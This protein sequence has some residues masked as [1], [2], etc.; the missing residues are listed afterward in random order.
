MKAPAAGGERAPRGEWNTKKS[1]SLL[2]QDC[3][4][5]DKYLFIKAERKQYRLTKLCN[6]L[7]INRGAY[8]AWDKTG[9]SKRSK[10]RRELSNII[11]KKFYEHKRIA[12]S[13]KITE[14]LQYDGEHVSRGLVAELMREKDLRSRVVKKYK[15]TTNSNHSLPVTPNLLLRERTDEERVNPQNGKLRDKYERTFTFDK[16]NTAWVSDITYIP[17]DEGW[18][19]LAGIMDLCGKEIVGWS[20][21][22]RMTKELVIRCFENAR[23]KRNN[24]KGVILHS[25]RGSQYCSK[26]YQRLLTK[27]EYKCS[28]SR[29]GNCW[30]NAPMESFWGKLK[31]E[32]LNGQH[33]RTR[34]EAKAAIFWYIEVYY[35]RKR[36]HAGNGY[37]TP[38]SSTAQAAWPFHSCMLQ[39]PI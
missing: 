19:Y 21:G 10:R 20:M 11:E 5:E 1:R 28:M 38:V 34:E 39:H 29:K 25:D 8:Y 3:K 31:Q 7:G 26:Q 35:H 12:G 23:K 22:D 9:E 2:R 27:Y 33:F 32:W 4:I 15:T 17:T 14:E 37:R 16:I 13:T 24:P 36:L 30:D 18:L 6:V